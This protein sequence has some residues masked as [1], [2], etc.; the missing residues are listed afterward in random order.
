ME[1]FKPELCKEFPFFRE[2]GTVDLL[3]VEPNTEVK[4]I[5]DEDDDYVE[6]DNYDNILSSSIDKDYVS[7]S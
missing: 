1:L 4:L 5:E 7:S 2:D 3:S 6:D